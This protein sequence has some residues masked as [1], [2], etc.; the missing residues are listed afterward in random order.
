MMAR[1]EGPVKLEAGIAILQP[2]AEACLEPQKLEE[3]RKDCL[4]RERGPADTLV[5]LLDSPTMRE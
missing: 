5:R 2:Q 4:P 1:E 3:A